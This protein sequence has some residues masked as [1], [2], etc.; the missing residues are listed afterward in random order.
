MTTENDFVWRAFEALPGYAARREILLSRA[1]EFIDRVLYAGLQP[2]FRPAT[3]GKRGSPAQIVD[4]VRQVARGLHLLEHGLSTID[5]ARRSTAQ[6]AKARDGELERLQRSILH[7]IVC[8]VAPRLSVTGEPVKL[9]VATPSYTARG[10]ANSWN[11]VFAG[12]ASRIERLGASA[13][14][15]DLKA[16][17]VREQWFT[18]FIG[19]LAEIYR[20]ATGTP[21]RAYARG[22][23]VNGEWRPPFCKFVG[24]IWP[25]FGR[26]GEPAPS[27]SRIRD[28][29]ANTSKLPPES[30]PE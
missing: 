26:D 4:A 8:A 19:V 22:Q 10:F 2:G 17:K 5:G 23:A 27:D 13:S 1:E 11:G 3:R 20:D 7:A 16:P 29:L 25:L 14:T 24:D 6:A 30:A 18:A 15:D 21:A 9:E 28:A 12:A